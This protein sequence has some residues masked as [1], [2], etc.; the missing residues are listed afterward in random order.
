MS[1]L[2][3][4]TFVLPPLACDA[5]SRQSRE[6]TLPPPSITEYQPRSTLVV[7]AHEVPRAKFPVVDFHGHPPNLSTPQ[8]IRQVVEAMDALNVQVMVQA[9]PSSGE[10]L[11][12]RSR[13]SA[14]RATPTASSS[15]RRSTSPTSVRAR[16]HAS[17]RSSRRT[18][19]RARW[20]SARS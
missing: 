16:A 1:T 6:S 2:A 10:R 3:A 15:S 5:Q 12:S 11:T 7:P 18:C 9:R 8:A 13:R 17:P 20:A 14:K 4:L 19:A